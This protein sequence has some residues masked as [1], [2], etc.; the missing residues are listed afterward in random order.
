MIVS[1]IRIFPHLVP[2]YSDGSEGKRFFPLTVAT[3]YRRRHSLL[4]N[5]YILTAVLTS[6]YLKQ[7]L[8]SSESPPYRL[9]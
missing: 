4:I 8:D 5:V 9:D 1:L 7:E 3:G 2:K 6:G